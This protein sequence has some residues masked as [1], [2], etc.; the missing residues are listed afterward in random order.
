MLSKTRLLFAA[1]PFP[2]TL[3]PPCLQAMLVFII[4]GLVILAYCSQA[5]NERTYQEVVWAVCLLG[6]GGF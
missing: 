6:E 3:A 4:S 1:R 5:S 2:H